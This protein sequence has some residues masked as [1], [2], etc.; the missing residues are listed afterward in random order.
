[1][2]QATFDPSSKWLLEEHGR[3]ILYLA[4]LRS[5]LSCKARKAEVV[6]PRKLPDGIL[7]VQFTKTQSGLVLVEVATYP[8]E[9]VVTQIADDI[10]LVRQARGVL[11]EALVI[12]LQEKG[13]YRVPDRVEAVS[14]MGWTT[15]RLSWKVIEVWNL[16]ANEL[17]EAPDVGIIPWVPLAR[18]D[19]SPEVLLQRCRDRIDREGGRQRANLLAV[20]QVFSKI[21][22]DRPNWLD[23]LGGSRAMIESPLIQEIVA[24]SRRDQ[25][26]KSI[27][28]F[29]EKRFKIV[30]PT[31]SAGLQ[32][33]K[34][35]ERLDRLTDAAALCKDMAAF[36]EALQA[37]L[38]APQPASTRG[39]RKTR[40]PAE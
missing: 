25:S 38:P 30:R 28:R 9:R 7:E 18:Y 5:V 16:D 29:L 12:V 40:K 39:R 27:L 13:S 37:E 3:A 14:E 8:E 33:V 4:G 2:P 23:I 1:M 32:Q 20:T 24:E 31:V 17:L 10:R 15:E 19:G 11:P 26:V 21:K 35:P 36:E 34:D 6:Q 22:Y